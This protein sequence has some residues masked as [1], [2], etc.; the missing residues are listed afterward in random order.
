MKAMFKIFNDD[1]E[2]EIFQNVINLPHLKYAKSTSEKELLEKI[3]SMNWRDNTES[4]PDFVSD[5]I[6]IDPCPKLLFLVYTC[7]CLSFFCW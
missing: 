4:R 7:M 1:S 3:K 6:M 5:E 2:W